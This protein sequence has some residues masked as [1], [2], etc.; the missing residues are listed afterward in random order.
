M[1]TTNYPAAR[2]LLDADGNVALIVTHADYVIDGVNRNNP[3]FFGSI[4]LNAISV[5]STVTTNGT[6][7]IN[8]LS[9][10]LGG[11]GYDNLSSLAT[12]IATLL[13][14]TSSS[15]TGVIPITK[16]GTGSTT[17]AA[18]LSALGAAS[19]VLYTATIPVS[20]TAATTGYTQ[21]VTV[22]GMTASD[23][24]VVGIVLSSDVDAA[25][26]QSTA[27]SCVNRITTAAG[28][29]TLYAYDTAPVTAMSLQL[30]TVRGF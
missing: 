30:L 10:S 20:W 6:T 8:P 16:G 7:T 5:F 27:F 19:A 26:L 3:E 9:A 13:G 4:T 14:Y 17:A 15:V 1:S 18:A 21:T 28:S 11:T 2:P 22:S 29:I 23:V 12:Q 25:K 24:P